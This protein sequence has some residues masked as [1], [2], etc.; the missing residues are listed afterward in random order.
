[1]HIKRGEISSKGDQNGP[2]DL[3][4]QVGGILEGSAGANID[5][6]AAGGGDASVLVGHPCRLGNN[7]SFVI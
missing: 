3:F 4:W 2:G 7:N 6:H 5:E 1:M